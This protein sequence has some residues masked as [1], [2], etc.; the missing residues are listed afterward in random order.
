MFHARKIR[1]D[2][3]KITQAQLAGCLGV[4]QAAVSRWER[5]EGAGRPVNIRIQLALDALVM[6]ATGRSIVEHQAALIE[7]AAA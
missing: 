3:L 1:C 6:K 5:A 7:Q 4:D 2:I